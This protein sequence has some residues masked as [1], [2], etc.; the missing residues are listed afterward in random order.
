MGFIYIYGE[1][2]CEDESENQFTCATSSIN[3]GLGG[4]YD[5]YVVERSSDNNDSLKYKIEKN[6]PR[7][8]YRNFT[9]LYIGKSTPN[10]TIFCGSK[11][12]DKIAIKPNKIYTCTFSPRV[13][14][15]YQFIDL[16]TDEKGDFYKSEGRQ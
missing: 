6:Q 12:V 14:C 8:N 11:V 3:N 10:Y 5:V 13:I 9:V 4:I 7:D 16:Y 15:M 1:T 2:K